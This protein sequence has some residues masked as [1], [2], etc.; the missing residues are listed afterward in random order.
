MACVNHLVMRFLR[1]LFLW[2]LKPYNYKNASDIDQIPKIKQ[3]QI[4][5]TEI[6]VGWFCGIERKEVMMVDLRG[7]EEQM[8]SDGGGGVPRAQPGRSGQSPQ[9]FYL[10]I[11]NST[12]C[13]YCAGH[14]STTT[15]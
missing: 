11:C 14:P 1:K 8:V 10:Q 7:E 13:T 5:E 4:W 15:Y 3:N 12:P 9:G 6:G 2:H